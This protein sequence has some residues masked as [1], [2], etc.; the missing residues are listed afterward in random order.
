MTL[1]RHLTIFMLRNLDV[2]AMGTWRQM[3]LQYCPIGIEWLAT[4]NNTI[5]STWYVQLLC[6]Y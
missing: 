5:G 6:I 4:A 1:D 3:C 2:G